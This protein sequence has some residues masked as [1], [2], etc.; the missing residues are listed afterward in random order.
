MSISQ[1]KI[2]SNGD[3]VNRASAATV[4]YSR[5]YSL[6]SMDFQRNSLLKFQCN[7][8]TSEYGTFN[9][10]YESNVIVFNWISCAIPCI[11]LSERSFVQP[12]EFNV[13]L[14]RWKWLFASTSNG[15]GYCR[16]V[17]ELIDFSST[18]DQWLY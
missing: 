13:Q 12:Q 14:H 16:L 17:S 3:I 6:Y 4:L 18:K 2:I 15:T 5:Y 7:W 9:G 11:L 8:F 1:Q 10:K